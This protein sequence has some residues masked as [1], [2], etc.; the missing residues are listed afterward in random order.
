M[1]HTADEQ[2]VRVGVFDTVGAADAAIGA[3]L[4]SG[5]TR[6]QLSVICS[7]EVKREHFHA[8]DTSATT[9]EHSAGGAVTGSAV[10]AAVA[11]AL[12]VT[13]L[14]TGAGVLVVMAGGVLL[15]AG[16]AVGGLVGAMMA[17][18]LTKEAAN[19]YDQAVT[20]GKILVVVEDASDE[21]ERNLVKAEQALTSAGS[22]PVPLPEG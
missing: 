9:G 3:L 21:Y 13:G 1:N 10:G 16:A 11:G 2:R 8:V 15:A 14:S 5:F 12:A 22:T 19:Y 7:D 6:D 17:R 4:R 20:D 18:G